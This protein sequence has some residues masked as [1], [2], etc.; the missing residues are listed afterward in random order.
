[1]REALCKSIQKALK[2]ILEESE[3]GKKLFTN[4]MLGI[5]AQGKKAPEFKSFPCC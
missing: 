1:L 3:E 2:T 4:K 5:T